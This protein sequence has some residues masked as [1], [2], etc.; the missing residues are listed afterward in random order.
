M[1]IIKVFIVLFAIAVTSCTQNQKVVVADE[2]EEIKFKYT[3]YSNEFELFAE[4]DP[5]I[6]G[7]S[8]NVLSHFTH[9]PE[10][11]ALVIG[12]I[13]LILTVDGKQTSQTLDVPTRKGIYSFNLVPNVPGNGS[14][15]YVI[16]GENGTSVILVPEVTVYTSHEQAHTASE[17]NTVPMVN[18]TV[19]TKEQS[20][21]IDF[22]TEQPQK[23][24]FGQIIKSTAFIQPAPDDEVI[25]TA[26][27]NGVVLLT[28]GTLLSGR[29]VSRNEDLFT[30]SGS[31]LAEDNFSVRYAEIISNYEKAKADYERA[32]ELSNDRIISEK[33]LLLSNNKYVNAKS[34]YDNLKNNFTSSGQ[35]VSSP[36]GGF[37]KQV[38]VK[39]GTYV[40]AG[41]PVIAISQNR[42]LLLTADVPQKYV[43]ILGL[44]KTANISTALDKKVYTL[45][46]LKGKV[47]SYGKSANTDN[48]LIPVNIQIENNG[49]FTSGTFAVVYLKTES[50]PQSLSVPNTALI[51]EQGIYSI[52]V[53]ITPELFE[54]REVL[55]GVTDGIR[56][57][58]LN[59]VT[60]MERV[61]SRGGIF[62]KLAQSTGTLDAHSGHVH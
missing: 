27:T 2:Q 32:K 51:E 33:D 23:G 46:Q 55:L 25:I 14:L 50:G 22:L 19:F 42:K 1:D 10:F 31:E 37:V 26:R 35:S 8:A 44:I 5:F 4:A 28:S 62:I 48:Y 39:N 30:I 59:G 18:T 61:V 17:N 16:T 3:A 21:K 57:E 58:I 49:M 45:E 43:S 53:Q 38:Y 47:V 41:Q 9:F 6:A 56:T 15:K 11:K 54:K 60:E 20:W 29:S 7:D 34:Q 12:K 40:V 24:S 52:Y 36:I 13:T